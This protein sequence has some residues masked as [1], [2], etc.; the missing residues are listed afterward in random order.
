MNICYVIKM[1]FIQQPVCCRQK[2]ICDTLQ[3]PTVSSVFS[4]EFRGKACAFLF[5]DFFW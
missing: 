4:I 1:L 3:V 5:K 2:F